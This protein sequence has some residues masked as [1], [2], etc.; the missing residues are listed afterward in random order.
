MSAFG[1]LAGV[2]VIEQLLKKA[3]DSQ[4]A[5]APELLEDSQEYNETLEQ[6]YKKQPVAPKAQS[7]KESVPR[8]V[9]VPY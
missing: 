7:A 8:V 5:T 9:A 3:D 2:R 6:L 4:L 1:I